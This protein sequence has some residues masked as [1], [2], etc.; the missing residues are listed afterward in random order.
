MDSSDFP[1]IFVNPGGYVTTILRGGIEIDL[2]LNSGMRMLHNRGRS[3][4]VS[5]SGTE[6]CIIHSDMRAIQAGGFVDATFYGNRAAC[7]SGTWIAFGRIDYRESYLLNSE[8]HMESL[9]NIR[10]RWRFPTLRYDLTQT[11]FNSPATVSHLLLQQC[12]QMIDNGRSVASADGRSHEIEIGEVQITQDYEHNVVLTVNKAND[13][14][15]EIQITEQTA[16]L[17]TNNIEM[18]V[19]VGGVYHLFQ[20]SFVALAF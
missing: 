5:D 2:T 4:A 15:L 1:Q 9:A 17:K 19:M 18:G 8:W 13:A 6:S 10:T 14:R 16:Q 20:P 11:V 3:L 7:F 12:R